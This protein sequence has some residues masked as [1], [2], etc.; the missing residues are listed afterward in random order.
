MSG[1]LALEAAGIEKS[2]GTLRVLDGV[3]LAV[4]RGSVLALLGPNGAGK[5]TTL[6]MCLGVVEPDGGTVEVAGHRLPRG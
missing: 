6:M 2:Y 5:T 3:D 1:E 4:P